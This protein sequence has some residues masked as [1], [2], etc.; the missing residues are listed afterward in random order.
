[1][2]KI[3]MRLFCSTIVAVI[4][5]LTANSG[6]AATLTVNATPDGDLSALEIGDSFSVQYQS[7]NFPT[8]SGADLELTYSSD[9]LNPTGIVFGSSFLLTTNPLPPSVAGSTGTI[10]FSTFLAPEVSGDIDLFSITFDVVG[11]GATN[12]VAN[13]VFAGFVGS[14]LSGMQINIDTVAVSTDASPTPVPLP[15]T[16]LL[17]LAGL[18]SFAF[19]S[20]PKKIR[21]STQLP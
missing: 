2:E 9:I 18:G 7:D 3:L 19:A 20:R 4:L 11:E 15:A 5:S 13:E 12:I 17:L 21:P 10:S 14:G 16:S 1:M 6:L 8:F